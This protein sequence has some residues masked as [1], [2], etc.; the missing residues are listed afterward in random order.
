MR[1][2]GAVFGEVMINGDVEIAADGAIEGPEL[3]GHNIII[4]GTVKARVVAT[5]KLSLSRTA[6]VE[7][8]IT[9]TALDMEAGAFYVGHITTAQ[10]QA[11]PG[12]QPS[13]SLAGTQRVPP[14]GLGSKG[15]SF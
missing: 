9:A 4:H 13:L 1:L 3:S 11:L 10:P 7:G 15:S 6:R 14:N 12:T 5:G 8:D 2:D